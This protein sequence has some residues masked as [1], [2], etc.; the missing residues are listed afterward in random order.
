MHHPDTQPVSTFI[1]VGRWLRTALAIHLTMTGI[2]SATIGV[3]DIVPAAT[4]LVPYFEVDL[5][6]GAGEPAITTDLKISNTSNAIVA[7]AT[8]YTE[9]GVPTINFNI[10]IVDNGTVEIDLHRLFTKGELG[11]QGFGDNCFALSGVIPTTISDLQA[12]HTGQQSNGLFAGECGG[13]ARGDNLA[14]G[15][16]TI[17]TVS[18]CTDE[19][20]RESSYFSNFAT[21]ENVLTGSYVLRSTTPAH[22]LGT[23]MVHIEASPL[24]AFEFADSFYTLFTRAGSLIDNREPL[25]SKW[26]IPY[27]EDF[28]Q[29]I[30]WRDR[31]AGGPSPCG[32]VPLAQ[33]VDSES[34][35]HDG[36]LLATP[37]SP[38]PCARASS[39][40]PLANTPS[41]FPAKTG[42]IIFDL[43]GFELKKIIEGG[44][45]GGGPPA[46]STQGTVLAIQ[47]IHPNGMSVLLPGTP[48]SNESEPLE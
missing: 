33:S 26:A 9:F 38:I 12:A 44:G 10:P 40:S 20:P 22:A 6:P 8:L 16:I 37:V 30:C 17:D 14:R 15:F 25:P 5:D 39:R 35:A 34:Y 36:T 31:L 29:V 46:N 43:R 3:I 1:A 21:N 27:F 2:A 32:L 13:L 11:F 19:T 47:E 41:A 24:V 28:S 18:D 23:A 48:L 42:T 45:A 4:L 7:H